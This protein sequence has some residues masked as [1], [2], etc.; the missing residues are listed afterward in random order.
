MEYAPRILIGPDVTTANPLRSI[1]ISRVAW[2]IARRGATYRHRAHVT[3][4]VD[5]NNRYLKITPLGDRI[6]VAYT[7]FFGE[8]PGAQTRP[9]LDT[10]HDRT[11][12]N[13]EASAFGENLGRQV[14]DG[15][16]VELDGKSHP[17]AWS[18]ISVGMGSPAIA[19]GTFSIDLVAWV[20]ASRGSHTLTLHDRFRIPHPGETEVKVEDSPGVTIVRAHVGALDDPQHDYRFVGPGGPITDDGLELRY[21][22]T[23]R[24]PVTPDVVCAPSAM[25]DSHTL[26]AVLVGVGL[27]AIAGL[28]VVL[29]RRRTA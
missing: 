7:V 19:A 9:S 21:D 16:D 17:I 28:T 27:A 24:A 23:A 10:D 5:D 13:A 2:D 20:C 29:V 22:A 12:S 25:S 6:R 15:L 8:V 18:E 26:V 4:S 1:A 11:I 14:A 3:P